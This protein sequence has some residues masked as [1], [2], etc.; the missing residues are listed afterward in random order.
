M[1]ARYFEYSGL[2]VSNG[3][4]KIGPDTLV[5]NMTSA[6]DC[7]S[8][9]L[10]L[11]QLSNPHDCYAIRPETFRPG[12]LPYRRRQ[13]RYWNMSGVDRI[14]LNFLGMF[15]KHPSLRR[16]KYIRFSECGDFASQMDVDKLDYVAWRLNDWLATLPGYAPLIWYGCS[17]R[18]DLDFSRCQE[19]LVKGSGHDKGNNGACIVRP[20]TA[21]EKARKYYFERGVR[22]LVCPGKCYGC[23]ICK[24]WD[25]ADIV[26][27]KH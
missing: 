12:T 3:N 18:S 9:R 7:P 14:I 26:I 24:T 27:A 4:T 5:F 22:Y 23:Q 10:G 15:K 8:R 17:A 19:L 16:I 6:T 25:R 13:A 20:L 21:S 11:C 2:E 1:G